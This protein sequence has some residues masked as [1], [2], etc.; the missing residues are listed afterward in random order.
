VVLPFAEIFRLDAKRLQ[1]VQ[2]TVQRAA[3]VCTLSA[4][5]QQVVG[6]AP[7]SSAAA[8]PPAASS[9]GAVVSLAELQARC[10]AWLADDALKL[11]ELRAGL[12]AAA[13]SLARR[14]GRVPLLA[15]AAAD[16]G[17][18]AALLSQLEGAVDRAVSSSH[19]LFATFSRR[20]LESLRLRVTRAL[21]DA[22]PRQ[23]SGAD[24]DTSEGDA[25]LRP[26]WGRLLSREPERGVRESVVPACEA[27]VAAAAS[28][29]ARLAR[30][31]AS[32]YR[33]HIARILH[34]MR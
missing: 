30:H 4:L 6:S 25:S 7:Q 24:A 10:V 11:P 21:H 19:P 32:V 13:D 16:A 23:S 12:V 34:A 2:N 18:S 8:A 1:D 20:V 5:V 17:A 29:L 22:L 26:F 15:P 27:D 33:E 14:L 31:E 9:P 3:L 28:M